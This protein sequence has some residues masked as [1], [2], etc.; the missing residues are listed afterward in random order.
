MNKKQ[1]DEFIKRI[2]FL[3]KDLSRGMSNL[4]P[5]KM[6]RD[7]LDEYTDE[8]SQTNKQQCFTKKP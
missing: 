8:D 7:I 3:I 2:S 6:I 4:D 5:L 1:A